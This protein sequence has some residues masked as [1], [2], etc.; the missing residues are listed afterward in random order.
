MWPQCF[1]A[2]ALLRRRP[3][4]MLVLL[5]RIAGAEAKRPS[6][7]GAR[8]GAAFLVGGQLP[9][10]RICCR[11]AALPGERESFCR[12]VFPGGLVRI[13]LPVLLFGV[14]QGAAHRARS[15]R[16]CRL[17]RQ[18]RCG[19]PQRLMMSE[20]GRLRGT[21]CP[22]PGKF[23]STSPSHRRTVRRWNSHVPSALFTA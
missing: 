10:V 23:L 13:F 21:H 11:R 12:L 19:W 4:I 5:D 18:R 17:G 6:T 9:A 2:S 7:A 14:M 22:L 3:R 16:R 8:P 20:A 15:R 1:L